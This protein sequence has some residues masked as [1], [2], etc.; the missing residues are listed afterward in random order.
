[1]PR[2]RPWQPKVRLDA[3]ASEAEEWNDWTNRK[4]VQG[5]WNPDG[6][7]VRIDRIARRACSFLVAIPSRS[8][9]LSRYTAKCA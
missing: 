3:T 6:A 2:P 9:F 7:R 1:M 8:N 5:I 4:A